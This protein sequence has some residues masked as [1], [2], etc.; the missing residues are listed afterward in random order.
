MIDKSKIIL[1]LDPDE[2]EA[3][4][5]WHGGQSSMLYAVASTGSLALGSVRPRERTDAGPS[6]PYGSHYRDLSD[7]EW[8]RDLVERLES[9][10]SE[11]AEDARE[12]SENPLDDTDDPDELIEHAEAL[13][14]IVE[15]C[16]AWLARYPVES[17]FARKSDGRYWSFTSVGSYTLIYIVADGGILCPDCANGDNGSEATEDP[18]ADKQWRL[19]GCQTYDEGPPIPCE[20]CGKEIESSYGDPSQPDD[21]SGV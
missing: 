5:A 20:H 8:K 11:S 4:C 14:S 19:I 12:R 6:D 3:A 10:A 21:T 1:E 7:L 13:E 2:I 17:K 9:E 16:R 18:I 15:K